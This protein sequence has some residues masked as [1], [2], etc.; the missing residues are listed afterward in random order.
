MRLRVL[1]M[2]LIALL[3]PGCE[4]E[5]VSYETG[6]K[7]KARLDPWLAAER[8]C[9]KSGYKPRPLGS[10]VAP[11][12]GD[13][14][15]FVPAAILSNESFV[16]QVN[17]WMH[18]GGHLIV[19]IEHADVESNDWNESCADF[20]VPLPCRKMLEDM[21]I[22]LNEGGV[23]STHVKATEVTLDDEIFAVNAESSVSVTLDGGKPGCF[24]SLEEGD[25]RLTVV[26][27]ARIFRNRWIG[28]NEHAGLLNQL[29]ESTGVQGTVM[30]IKGSNL[31]IWNLLGRYLWPVLWGL[32]LVM[33]LGLWMCLARFGPIDTA[34]ETGTLRGYESH[35]EAVGDFQWRL[36]RAAGL[37]APLRAQI[38]ERGQRVASRAGQ[39]DHDFFQFLGDRAAIPRERVQRALTE[40][41]IPDSAILTRTTADLQR[42]L[43]VLH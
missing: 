40:L 33:L 28:E 16:R 25:G 23:T 26:T 6:Y 20:S 14:V 13:A 32:A 42:L 30:F 37:V 17:Q 15:C 19:L 21:E 2:L 10:W 24:V 43:Q 36:D 41:K 4:Y 35:L 38:I 11:Q 5:E 3:L 1:M 39:R 22:Q 12:A 34:A 31:S 27:D 7:G 29:L 9:E 8:F 18:D